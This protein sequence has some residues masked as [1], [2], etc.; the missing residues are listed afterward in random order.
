MWAPLSAFRSR[1]FVIAND[2]KTISS[3]FVQSQWQKELHS[4]RG[5]LRQDRILSLLPRKNQ[6]IPDLCRSL[7]VSLFIKKLALNVTSKI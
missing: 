6:E 7:E 2:V 4:S 3:Y 5:A 1:F